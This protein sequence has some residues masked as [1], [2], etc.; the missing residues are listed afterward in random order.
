M[1][2][3]RRSQWARRHPART[4]PATRHVTHS[5]TYMDPGAPVGIACVR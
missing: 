5:H 4:R 1:P 2:Q 3:P